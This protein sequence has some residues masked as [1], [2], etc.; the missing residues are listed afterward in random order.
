MSRRISF[1]LLAMLLVVLVFI[2]YLNLRPQEVSSV[3]ASIDSRYQP[4]AVEN[5]ALRLDLLDH[6]KTAQYEG[7][8]RN[9]FS[10]KL[11]APPAPPVVAAPPP[12]PSGP[13]P[14]PPLVVPA[15]FFGYVTDSRTGARRAFFSEGDE[16]YVVGVGEVLLGRFRLLQIGNSTAE[17]EETSS[18]RR[19]TLTIQEPGPS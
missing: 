8:R 11:P 2:V 14:V 1:M 15:T 5:P 3:S 13:P 10:D 19:A 4:I 6:L 16:V 17:L 12:R 7:T 9:I 18:G